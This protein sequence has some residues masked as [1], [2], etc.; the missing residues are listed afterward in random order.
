MP[1]VRV[2]NAAT[3]TIIAS[4][5]PLRSSR[6]E[7]QRAATTHSVNGASLSM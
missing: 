1:A 6:R 5:A 4:A 7:S 2:A 3:A